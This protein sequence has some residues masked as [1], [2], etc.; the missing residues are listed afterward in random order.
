M[1]NP[2]LQEI[3]L[4]LLHWW[5]EGQGRSMDTEREATKI[6]VKLLLIA[7]GDIMGENG[8]KFVVIWETEVGHEEKCLSRKR[9]QV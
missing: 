5:R 4:M 6:A 7:G 1:W 9:G 3:P 2:H 8:H